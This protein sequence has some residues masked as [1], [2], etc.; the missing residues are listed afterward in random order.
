MQLADIPNLDEQILVSRRPKSW[1]AVIHDP[2]QDLAARLKNR[3]STVGV[4]IA[5]IRAKH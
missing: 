1:V 2:L 4:I 3:E 5:Q